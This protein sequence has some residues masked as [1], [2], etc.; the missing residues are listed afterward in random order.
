MLNEMQP[1]NKYEYKFQHGG[2]LC[3]QARFFCLSLHKRQTHTAG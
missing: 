3:S 1:V 2:L